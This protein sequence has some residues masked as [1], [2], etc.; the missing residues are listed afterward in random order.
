MFVFCGGVDVFFWHQG[1]VCGGGGGGGSD[2]PE[3]KSSVAVGIRDDVVEVR[4]E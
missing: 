1:D 2:S 4:D 3:R